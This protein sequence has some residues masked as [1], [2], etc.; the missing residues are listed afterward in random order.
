MTDLKSMNGVTLAMA[1]AS[2]RRASSR[3]DDRLGLGD[4]IK[5][6]FHVRGAGRDGELETTIVAEPSLGP[7]RPAHP[8]LAS[9]RVHRAIL[10]ADVIGRVDRTNYLELE[11]PTDGG[12][13]GR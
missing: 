2:T 7:P 3:T 10:V 13:R 1:N 9:P 4:D 11:G 8:T 5:V 6:T 12:H